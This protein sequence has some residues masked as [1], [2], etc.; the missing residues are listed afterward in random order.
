MHD[1]HT[2]GD[3]FDGWL[4]VTLTRLALRVAFAR[5][6]LGF[7]FGTAPTHAGKHR[8]PSSDVLHSAIPTSYVVP[9]GHVHHDTPPEAR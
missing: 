8:G 1:L 3:A 5:R 6:H 9:S 2:P 4:H 7:A